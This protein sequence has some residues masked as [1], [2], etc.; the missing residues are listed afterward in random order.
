MLAYK[1]VWSC[2]HRSRSGKCHFPNIPQMCVHMPACPY[3]ASSN[4]QVCVKLFPENSK[5]KERN[6]KAKKAQVIFSQFIDD[7]VKGG[8]HLLSTVD[9]FTGAVIRPILKIIKELEIKT[10]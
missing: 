4:I 6:P 1:A 7:N 2:K 8:E 3:H 9:I 5:K 10:R